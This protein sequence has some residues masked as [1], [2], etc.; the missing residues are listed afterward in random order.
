MIQEKYQKRLDKARKEKISYMNN[1][2]WFKFFSAIEQLDVFLPQA[3]I[4][5]LLDKEIYPFNFG[6]GFDE[7]GI[8]DGPNCPFD[9]KE[10]EWFF[11]P[12]LQEYERFNREEKLQSTFKTVDL[13]LL[14]ETLKSLGRYEFDIG[15]NGLKLYGYK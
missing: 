2:K 13:P 8:L 10:I 11:I 4:K 12:A 14:V 15:E 3:Q 5:F 6:G 1:T 7:K 9:Y